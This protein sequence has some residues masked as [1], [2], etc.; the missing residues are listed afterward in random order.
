MPPRKQPK[1]AARKQKRAANPVRREGA[2]G[3][4]GPTEKERVDQQ[5][6]FLSKLTPE[7]RK[8]YLATPEGKKTLR[9]IKRHQAG[10]KKDSVFSKIENEANKKP[11]KASPK[12]ISRQEALKRTSKTDYHVFKNKSKDGKPLRNDFAG[13]GRILLKANTIKEGVRILKAFSARL[14]FWQVR[15]LWKVLV[16]NRTKLVH[17]YSKS[18]GPRMINEPEVARAILESANQ[19][20][21]S[22]VGE[23]GSDPIAPSNVKEAKKGF[24]IIIWFNR[25]SSGFLQSFLKARGV[26]S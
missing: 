18:R 24:E 13:G 1:V 26:K 11:S 12:A 25:E 23:T 21:N 7:G 14:D 15:K 16:N 3:S 22:A 17:G 6:K 9:D 4:R 20:A 5:L 10:I 8:Q 2:R 19:A